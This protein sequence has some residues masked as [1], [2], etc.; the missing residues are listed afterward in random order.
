MLKYK[1]K[2]KK[3]ILHPSSLP[4]QAWR[5]SYDQEQG[6]LWST[7]KLSTSRNSVG[8]LLKVYGYP[9]PYRWVIGQNQGRYEVNDYR[10]IHNS[11][12]WH[13]VGTLYKYTVFKIMNNSLG[14]NLFL[15]NWNKATLIR[16][17]F[18]TVLRHRNKIIN[19]GASTFSFFFNRNFWFKLKL[20][21]RLEKIKDSLFAYFWKFFL[22]KKWGNTKWVATRW[23]WRNIIYSRFQR[24]RIFPQWQKRFKWFRIF[25]YRVM[26]RFRRVQ[27]IKK[28]KYLIWFLRKYFY[29][30]LHLKEKFFKKFKNFLEYSNFAENRL[31]QAV[32]RIG[33]VRNFKHA[34]NHIKHGKVYVNNKCI[35]D[36]NYETKPHDIIFFN[37]NTRYWRYR[38]RYIKFTNLHSM[39]S[40][41]LLGCKRFKIFCLPDTNRNK[42]K[43]NIKKFRLITYYNYRLLSKW[44]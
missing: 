10:W 13:L 23:R 29:K 16:K 28:R 24:K 30:K 18:K 1:L 42:H 19:Y 5:L 8:K 17:Y 36:V 44:D 6:K 27:K 41:G 12:S 3:N 21:T 39:N 33:V 22:K 37:I 7:I 43:K 31:V 32:M 20:Y 26:W 35:R 15:L 34:C 9:K 4:I 11:D 40:Y 25:K 14:K 2:L 38:N